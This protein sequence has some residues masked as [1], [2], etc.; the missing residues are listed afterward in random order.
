MYES[1]IE[2]ICGDIKKQID[3]DIY[4]VT[5]KYDIKVDK[6]ELIQALQYDR[7]QYE[8][9]Y[10]DG[11]RDAMAE[12]VRCKD[13]YWWNKESTKIKGRYVC[14]RFSMYGLYENHTLEDDF[15]SYGE[16]RDNG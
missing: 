12:L 5:Q 6:N 8:K 4:R 14:N 10:A 9:G 2:I 16:R 15:C 1:P 3:N 11:K 7:G 13:C